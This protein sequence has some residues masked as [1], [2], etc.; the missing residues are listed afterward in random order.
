VLK[1]QD[2]DS[3]RSLEKALIR[4]LE[5]TEDIFHLAANQREAIRSEDWEGLRAVLDEKDQRILDFEKTEK[6]IERWKPLKDMVDTTPTVETIL[7]RTEERLLAIQK[8]E[9]ECRTVLITRRQETTK[10]LEEVK[11]TRQVIKRFRPSRPTM[12]RF[13]D[14]RK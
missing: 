11:R 7:S 4:R 5:L 13:V 2:N 6:C 14:L 3:Q 12:S 10:A 8:V 9:E 1:C